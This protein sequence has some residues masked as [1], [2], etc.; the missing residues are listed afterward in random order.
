V[1]IPR[2]LAVDIES[3]VGQLTEAVRRKPY[4]EDFGVFLDN[5]LQ[6]L[7]SCDTAG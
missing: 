6:F 3:F 7:Y 5:S 1:L 2:Y 4:G